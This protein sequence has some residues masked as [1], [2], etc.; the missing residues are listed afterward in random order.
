[1]Y[2]WIF[3]SGEPL[4][5]DGRN[6][7]PMRAINLANALVK[8]GH[9]VTIWSSDFYHQKKK[10]RFKIFKKK[11][12]NRKLDI[13]LIPSPGYKKNFS[14]LRLIDHLI[15]AHNLKK[16][17]NLETS[18][19][20]VA[21][22]GYPPIETAYVMVNWL[23]KKN[24][25]CLLDVKDQWPSLFLDNVP[26]IIKPILRL[27]L[28]PY[29]YIAKKTI[30]NSSG[31][32]SMS[33]SFANWILN[34]SNRKKNKFDIIAPLT[35]PNDKLTK[36][37]KKLAISWWAKKNIKKNKIHRIIFIGSFSKAFDFDLIFKAANSLSN[38]E[39]NCEFILCGDGELVNYLK[40]KS[41]EYKNVKIIKWIDK[42]KII[43]LSKLS[44]AFIAPYKNKQ[45]F[46][47][48]IP[49]KIVDAFRL[50][51]PLLSPLKGEVRNLIKKYNVGMTYTNYASL[52][53]NIKLIINDNN[54]K[55]IFS[56]NSKKLYQE[57]F[58]FNK[59]YNE[60]ITNLENLKK[61]NE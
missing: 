5:I 59:T 27:I 1:M 49:N 3:Q 44:L 18:L 12:I 28:F 31:I 45:N 22:V 30:K 37:E 16:K 40:I 36:S 4:H 32:C 55:K 10:H 21:F 20:D 33:K 35:S 19:P 42:S 53:K 17:I 54:L 34:F 8:K 15:L 6:I 9:I 60:L 24:I 41:K 57:K 13:R 7:R 23:K 26:K 58:E 48:N 43:V 61:I 14:T 47:M 52:V 56:N 46:L 38:E 11:I 51:M 50:E 25:P 2:I 39:I 29:F